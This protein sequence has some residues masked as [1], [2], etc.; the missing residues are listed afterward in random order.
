MASPPIVWYCLG[1]RSPWMDVVT[2]AFLTSAASTFMLQQAILPA[3]IRTLPPSRQ[4]THGQTWTTHWITRHVNSILR[5]GLFCRS[6][7][8]TSQSLE[9]HNVERHQTSTNYISQEDSQR[10]VWGQ[11]ED[12]WINSASM[13]QREVNNLE[14]HWTGQISTFVD[15]NRDRQIYTT[16]SKHKTTI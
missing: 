15:R 9:W 16:R 4:K 3:N 5:R 12:Q 11:Q 13:S 1:V 8:T 10:D 14:R 2:S 6:K 7:T